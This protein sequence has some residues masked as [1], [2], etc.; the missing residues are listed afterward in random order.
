MSRILEELAGDVGVHE[1]TLRRAVA[2]GT[3]RAQRESPYKLQLPVAERHYVRT[4]WAAI[5][6]LR[7]ALRTEPSVQCAVLFGSTA[8]GD[9]AADSDLDVLVWM[10]DATHTARHA[11]ARRLTAR[12]GRQV[13]VVDVRDARTQ[14]SLLEA[15]L[16]EGRVLVDRGRYWPALAASATGLRRRA[17]RERRVLADRAAAARDFFIAAAQ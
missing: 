5:G 7:T 1:R 2:E 4:H 15:I 10:S 17:T 14:P 9:D 8:R 6:A 16:R 13:Q 11:L 12:V 3:I